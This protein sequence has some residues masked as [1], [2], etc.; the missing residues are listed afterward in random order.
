MTPTRRRVTATDGVTLAVYENGDPA[1]PT[2]VAVHGYPDNHT[3][4][5]GVA[6]LLAE[7]FHVVTYDVRG[8]GDSAKP[9]RRSAY[10]IPQLTDDLAAVLD[11]VSPDAPVH[12][13]AHDWGSIQAWPGLAGAQLAGRIATFTS[14]SGPSLEHAALWLR[15]G[16]EHPRAALRQL[17]HSYYTVLFQVPRLPELVVRSAATDRKL[18]AAGHNHAGRHVDDKV[19]GVMLYR[20]NM[21]GSV[22]RP[23]PRPVQIPVQLIV[24]EDDAFVT[25]QLAIEAAEP[26]VPDLTVHRID[27]GHWVVTERP[28]VI[29]RL[30]A[31]HVQSHLQSGVVR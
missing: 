10:G 23:H 14:I 9:S 30:T 26:W 24:P 7:E 31:D 20:A 27:G 28:D 8:A 1:A 19:N 29:A 11:A 15:R 3:V 25:P 16:R 5:D 18:R 6:E 21:F 4:W 22:G 2:I 12:L 17:A 13:L